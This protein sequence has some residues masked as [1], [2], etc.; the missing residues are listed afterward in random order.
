MS[1]LPKTEALRFFMNDWKGKRMLRMKH[2]Q[3]KIT[4]VNCETKKPNLSIVVDDNSHA[5]QTTCT[6]TRGGAHFNQCFI[7]TLTP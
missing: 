5:S 2:T 3:A 1:V 4:N 7:L 6:H